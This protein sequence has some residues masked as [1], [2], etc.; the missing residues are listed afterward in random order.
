MAQLGS[1]ALAEGL[2]GL[3]IQAVLRCCSC[4][5][6]GGDFVGTK[7]ALSITSTKVLGARKAI[8]FFPMLPL[9]A[10]IKQSREVKWGRAADK[11]GAFSDVC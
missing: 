7:E 3:A 9:M 11:A 1:G 2:G 8:K 6:L 5:C 10:V 4:Q